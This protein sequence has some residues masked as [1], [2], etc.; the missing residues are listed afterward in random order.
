MDGRP[1]VDCLCNMSGI[2]RDAFQNV[3]ELLDD[4][5]ARAAAA[6]EPEHMNY[7]A[8]HARA[9]QQQGVT[10]GASARLFSN[11]SGDYGSMVNER[12][13]AG[14][15]ENSAELGDTWAARNAFSYGEHLRFLPY[16]LSSVNSSSLQERINS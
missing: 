9:L 13:G 15:W 16:L 6:D 12:V 1:R 11:P 7:I 4:L 8:K 3:V 5:F 10:A 14:N 2:F